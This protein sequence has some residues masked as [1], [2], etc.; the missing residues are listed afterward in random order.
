MWLP[1]PCVQARLRAAPGADTG[2]RGGVMGVQDLQ[3]LRAGL[4]RA[5]AKLDEQASALRGHEQRLLEVVQVCHSGC[6][7]L[8]LLT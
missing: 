1:R 7:V 3:L 8:G 6:A 4:E 5:E 2:V